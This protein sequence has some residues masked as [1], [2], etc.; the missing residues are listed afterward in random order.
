MIE[1]MEVVGHEPASS[2][3][4]TLEHGAEPEARAERR[5]TLAEVAQLAG[6]SLKTASR[7]VNGEK[8]VAADTRERVLAAAAQL[9]FRI[10][11]MASLLKRGVSSSMVALITGD[12]ANPFY[13]VLAKGVESELRAHGLQL[14]IASSDER[15][16]DEQKLID[17]FVS[18]RVR[19]LIIV[20]T[21]DS[22]AELHSVQDRGISM[23]FVDRPPIGLD[24]DSFVLDN[25]AGTRSAIE[26]LLAHGHRRIGYISDFSRLPTHRERARG[27]TDAMTSAGVPDWHRYVES[28]AHDGASAER[29][30]TALLQRE[31]PP[32]AF[33][34]G[35]N[36]LTI[37]AV[38]AI[39]RHAPQTALIG[40]DDFEL[41]DVLGVTTVSHAPDE[42]GR[43]AAHRVL[44]LD[45]QFDQAVQRH[46]LPT[47]II[48]RGSGERVPVG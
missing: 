48:K 11:A 25:Y 27:F 2:G 37:G 42:M 38:K 28:G 1:D 18:R 46:V 7:A 5:P 8:Y 31:D 44:Q 24:A 40:F 36:Q 10:N 29:L 21:M 9:G 20:S 22:H 47:R 35:N 6:V 41:A 34:T 12:L 19:A 30:V 33:F 4:G 39:T 13:S 14:T 26:Q 43:L 16:E 17:E 32:T 15:V 45:R 3:V 23:I